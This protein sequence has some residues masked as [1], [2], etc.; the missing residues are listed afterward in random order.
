MERFLWLCSVI[1]W[2]AGCASQPQIVITSLPIADEAPPASAFTAEASLQEAGVSERDDRI[3]VVRV[4]LRNRTGRTVPF[5]PEHV[6]VVDA[7]GELFVR[8]SSKW[9]HDYYDARLRG[10]PA[11][12]T[13]E[14]IATFPSEG[15]KVGS[16]EFR[17]PALTAVQRDHVVKEMARLV[18]EVFVGPQQDAPGTFWEKGPQV[19]LGVRLKEVILQPDNGVSGHVYFYHA[20][21][22]KPQHPLRLILDLQGEVYAFL[23]Q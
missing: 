5:G 21:G 22:T 6:Y 7:T 9:L 12:P 8:I 11:T 18:E 14:A 20:A 10:L 2:L 23:F 13:R 16:A 3:V 19:A 1:L 15:V 4:S 17:S